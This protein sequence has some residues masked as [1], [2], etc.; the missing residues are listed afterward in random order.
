MFKKIILL[1]VF[2]FMANVF[3]DT[4]LPE[5]QV[6]YQGPIFN[7]FFHPLI[8]YPNLAFDPK[9]DHLVY[10]DSW[11][12][13]TRE[14]KK[15]MAEVYRRGFILVSPKDLFSRG[16]RYSRENNF[17]QKKIVITGG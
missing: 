5:K 8:A 17:R 6:N 3:A 16:K 11:F 2:F 1:V 4:R 14:F 10:I 7:I 12:V 13:T 9:N 15:I